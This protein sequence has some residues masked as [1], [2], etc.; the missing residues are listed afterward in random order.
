ML[1]FVDGLPDIVTDGS[2]LPVIVGTTEGLLDGLVVLGKVDGVLDSAIDGSELSAFVGNV[3]GLPE[4]A[5]LG[6]ELFVKL[7]LLETC[8]LGLDDG[9]DVVGV[10]DGSWVSPI[11]GE[12]VGAEVTGLATGESVGS[13]QV[14]SPPPQVQHA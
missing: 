5:T 12:E 10:V 7:G 3:D 6:E 13:A 1:G 9:T 8:S 11:V 2:E 4:T 14:S